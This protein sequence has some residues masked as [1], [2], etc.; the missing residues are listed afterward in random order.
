MSASTTSVAADATTTPANPRGR[1]ILASL[2]GTTIEFYDFYVY[3]TAAVLVF[4]HLF[5]PPGNETAAL[6]SSFAI[7]GAA[8]VA[9]PLGAVF[10]GHLGDKVGRKTTLVAALLTM[11][12]E[13]QPS[14]PR[15]GAEALYRR[16]VQLAAELILC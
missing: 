13:A 6:L 2:I 15:T 14:L 12:I 5:F 4:P 7:F 8:M 1:V 10:F 9:R 16:L 11:G 3:A